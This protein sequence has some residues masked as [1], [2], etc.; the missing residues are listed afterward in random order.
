ME[1]EHVFHE[2]RII[3]RKKQFDKIANDETTQSDEQSFRIDY[4]LYIVDQ[5]FSS[6]QSRFEQFKSYNCF[7]RK[8]FFKIKIDKILPKINN[9]KD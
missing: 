9:K 6:I 1:I 5:A 8:K 2:K 4:F 3:R 7:C